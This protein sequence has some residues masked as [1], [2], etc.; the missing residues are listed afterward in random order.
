MICPPKNCKPWERRYPANLSKS[1][2]ITPA[3]QSR[4]PRNAAVVTSGTSIHHTNSNK[5]L[6]GTTIINFERKPLIAE[7]KKLMQNE[8][9]EWVPRIKPLA[10]SVPPRPLP[11]ALSEN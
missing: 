7:I 8:H 5:V 11:I 3:I 10:T 1:S 9:L 2:S 6:K 4:S